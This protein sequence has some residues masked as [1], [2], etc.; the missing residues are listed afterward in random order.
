VRHFLELKHFPS[1]EIFGEIDSF[2]GKGVIG[3]RAI[4]NWILRFADGDNNLRNILRSSRLRSAGNVTEIR[5]LLADC[6]CL[7]QK[8]NAHI[9]NI[10]QVTV[11]GMLNK[12]PS[13]RTI[14]YLWIPHLLGDDHEGQRSHS[15]RGLLECLKSN[16]GLKSANI[17]Q[18]RNMNSVRQYAIFH[19]SGFGPYGASL[20]ATVDQNEEN[21]DFG[22]SV[23]F[24]NREHCHRAIIRNV[25]S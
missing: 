21:D 15:S 19:V 11:K 16:S 14:N 23:M 6:H 3:L 25:Q 24:W 4:Q 20:C 17:N 7:S 22:R 13:L 2:Y 12:D 9:R 5:Q 1:A 10:H 8:K 18:G